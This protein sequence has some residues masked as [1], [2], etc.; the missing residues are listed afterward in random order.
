MVLDKPD[1]SAQLN[2]KWRETF[3]TVTALL[4]AHLSKTRGFQGGR[5]VLRI[6][7][8]SIRPFIFSS[9]DAC[10][11]Y[12]PYT[13]PLSKMP[14]KGKKKKQLYIRKSFAPSCLSDRY[15]PKALVHREVKERHF[16]YPPTLW[17]WICLLKNR[18]IS[19]VSGGSGGGSRSH[20][21][22]LRRAHRHTHSHT[23]TNG[24]KREEQCFCDLGEPSSKVSSA[25]VSSSWC[26]FTCAPEIFFC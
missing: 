5:H 1:D 4:V 20:S 24:K 17:D 13:T 23:H 26:I 7:L 11:I 9:H 21:S 12:F 15:A 6:L 3:D 25:S 2:L 18:H 8:E 14:G 22:P 19:A 10:W 16:L